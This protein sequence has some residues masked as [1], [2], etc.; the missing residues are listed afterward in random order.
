M[1]NFNKQF[2]VISLTLIL[3]AGCIPTTPTATP[4]PTPAGVKGAPG[5][6]D[7][8]Y[9]KLGNGGYDVQQYTI[10][11]AVDPVPN[12]VT[13][14]TAITATATESLSSFNLD[15]HGLTVDSITVNEE[16]AKFSRSGDELTIMPA[17][18]LELNKPFTTVVNYHGSPQT[19]TGGGLSGL[20][21]SHGVSG[22]INAWGEPDAASTWFADNNHPRDKA[23]YRFE[24]T[25]P[26]PW[27]V[28]AT[29][30]LKGTSKS[31]D[32][33]TY[34]WE[35]DKPMATYLASI[36][37]DQYDL[38]TQD[39]PHGIKI[40]NYFPKDLDNSYRSSFAALPEMIG[41][42]EGFF[43]PYPFSE[44]GVVV[45]S[46]DG[47][48]AQTQVAL[49]AQTMSIHCPVQSMT[50]EFT[51]VHELAHMWFG[52]S[53]SLENWKDIWLKEGFAT[54]ASWLWGA[55]GDPTDL[56]RIAE[57]ARSRYQD[58]DAPVAD[59]GPENL[60]TNE[61]YT[62]GAL[63][64]YALQKEVGDQVFYKILQ[65]YTERYKYGNAGSDEFISV[66][67]DVSGKDLGSFFDAWLFSPTLPELSQ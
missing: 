17:T 26:D 29:G 39:G 49:E 15:F 55:K 4:S 34:I 14:S 57:Q 44:Y 3:L 27:M 54:Y 30:S 61:S 56:S 10:A 65:T 6:G 20:G 43:G 51:I 32:K 18:V 63:V 64:L 47:L 37:I 5:I 59:P 36:S 38:I 21:W 8:Y 62:G 31:G 2:L 24:I 22:A 9:P 66:A 33:T 60:Y 1:P 50:S 12:T 42:F 48:C 23:T 25:V 11:L 45:A 7:P 16:A 13:G 28:A 41:F 35:M 40:R 46:E 52:D 58:S 67:E 53:V 19:I